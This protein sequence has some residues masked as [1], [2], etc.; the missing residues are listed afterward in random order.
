M[1]WLWRNPVLLIEILLGF[2]CLVYAFWSA[3]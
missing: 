1:R 2:G 3:S